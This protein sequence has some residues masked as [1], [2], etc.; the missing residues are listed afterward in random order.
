MRK[1]IVGTFIFLLFVSPVFAQTLLNEP[2]ETIVSREGAS[3]VLSL[4]NTLS[5]WLFG[6]LAAVAVV[7]IILSAYNFLTSGGDEAKLKKAK[8]R[9]LYAVIAFVIGLL[10]WSIVLLVSSFFD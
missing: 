3:A 6:I 9:L 1:A 7:L 2:P 8:D 5:L 4:I 10:S